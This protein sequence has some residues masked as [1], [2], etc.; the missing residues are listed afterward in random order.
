MTLGNRKRMNI[1]TF[2]NIPRCHFLALCNCIHHINAYEENNT[3]IVDICTFANKTTVSMFEM[4]I[5]SDPKVRN[6]IK[7]GYGMIRL[8]IDLETWTVK[9]QGF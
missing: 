3:I 5:L 4:P 2:V 1:T 6:S 7:F 8:V 9:G